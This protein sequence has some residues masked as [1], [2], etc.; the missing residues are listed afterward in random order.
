MTKDQVQARITLADKQKEKRADSVKE[1]LQMLGNDFGSTSQSD[2]STVNL[3]APNFLMSTRRRLI[4][5]LYPADPRFS[6][7]PRLRGFEG[8]AEVVGTLLEYYWRELKVI[9]VMRRIIDNALVYGYGVAKVGMGSFITGVRDRE[10]EEE[11][12]DRIA[13]ENE[14][15]LEGKA[16]EADLYD[17]HELD[18]E[19]HTRLL[20]SPGLLEL[21]NVGDVI[22]KANA[23]MDQH[24]KFIESPTPTFPT[25]AG[26]GPSYDWPFIE[27]VGPDVFWD[28]MVID[29][30]DS[31]YIVHV[32]TK[33]LA[34]VK[35]DPLYP[36]TKD[37]RA[38]SY[39][40]EELDAS[41]LHV[42]NKMDDSTYIP[43]ELGTIKLYEIWDADGR[44]V[45]TYAKD[46]DEPV[47]PPSG[48]AWPNHI[49]GFPFQWLVFTDLPG[50]T[51]GPGIMDY[52]KWPQKF[53][54][55]LYSE[56][57]VHSD[58]SGIK[59]EVDENRL[60]S[61]ETHTSVEDKL[62]NPTSH[63]AIFVQEKG[64]IAPIVQAPV[65]PSKLQLLS[66]LQNVI[67][68]NAGF[69][70]EISGVG[71]SDTATQ[72][73]IMASSA[74][75]LINDMMQRLNRFQEDTARDLLG[76]VREFGPEEQ[77]FYVTSPEGEQWKNYHKNDVQTDWQVTV[78]M[79]SPSQS[80]TDKQEWLNMFSMFKDIMDPAGRQ[81]FMMDGMKL[82]GVK[83]PSLYVQYPSVETQ[84]NINNENALMQMGQQ[85]QAQQ[86]QEHDEHMKGHKMAVE[87]WQ[88]YIFQ[89]VD[90]LMEQNPVLQQNPKAE[91]FIQQAIMADPNGKAMVV[92]TQLANQHMQ[93][94]QYL[95][96]NEGTQG[97]GES[98]RRREEVPYPTG[99]PGTINS[100]ISNQI[101][102]T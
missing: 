41:A 37:L 64:A 33:R 9:N 61:R 43:E 29:P 56:L 91:Q 58:R 46:Q 50:E 96:E 36:N 52:I 68:E 77:V 71:G 39:N 79:P 11:A 20:Q 3:L 90:Q 42:S 4:A 23:H 44:E 62:A 40:A 13:D 80:T 18:M 53:L 10:T 5:Q 94:H 26:K 65:D 102:A 35:A 31:S 32:V 87:E 16:V 88:K 81:Q 98:G 30:Q 78:D 86:G 74:N 72:A 38:D 100:I 7:V 28:P 15:L 25:K 93:E 95:Q 6:C 8:R 2:G 66:L 48:D 45:G 63:V 54:M 69:S 97:K 73:S 99:N 67:Y 92:A 22:E 24:T 60:S 49:Q 76:I 51:H 55:R 19:E 47:R 70:A 75:T 89:L 1:T 82:F 101:Q 17:D 12:Y 84:S 21:P 14:D 34:D 27:S 83:R 85:V 59:V 57:A